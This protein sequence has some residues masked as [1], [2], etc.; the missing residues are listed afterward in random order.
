MIK[1][2]K[3]NHIKLSEAFLDEFYCNQTSYYGY[4]KTNETCIAI[5]IPSWITDNQKGKI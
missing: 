3:T 1:T 4:N 2:I 5:L